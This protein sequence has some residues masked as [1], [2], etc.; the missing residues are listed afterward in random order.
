M[1]EVIV[2]QD[3]RE[4][5]ARI[6]YE[7]MR[8]SQNWPTAKTTRDCIKTGGWDSY[9]IVQA[10]ARH[11]TQAHAAGLAEG[12]AMGIEAALREAESYRDGA[13]DYHRRNMLDRRAY[14]VL[15][16]L[17]NVVGAIR[18]LSPAAIIAQHKR[19]EADA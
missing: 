3:D 12:V 15:K 2:T 5:A 4:A 19:G 6:C 8:G 13:S 16:A 11:R 14:S 18:D 10:F 7:Q 17:A 9:Y 1:T